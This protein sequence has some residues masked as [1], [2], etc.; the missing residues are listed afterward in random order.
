MVLSVTVSQ[1]A[2]EIGVRMALGASP[3]VI[4]A[5]LSCQGAGLVVI[6]SSVGCVS[7]Y[8]AGRAVQT[9]LAGVA[10]GESLTFAAAIGI[11]AMTALVGTVIPTFRA[12]RMD[13]VTAIKQRQK[14]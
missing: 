14:Q 11:S 7:V 1:R 4:L 8:A 2:P 10:P 9:V 13:P 5:V 3:R 6:G 12:A